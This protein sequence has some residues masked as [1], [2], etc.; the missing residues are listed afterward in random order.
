MNEQ[1]FHL[2]AAETRFAVR[3]WGAGDALLCVHGGMG[4]DASYLAVEGITGLATAQRRVILYDQRGHGGSSPHSEG[5]FSI[6]RW[7]R[8]VL[9]VADALNLDRFALLG[10][11]YG[12]FIAISAAARYPDRI[13]ALVL[14]GTSAGPVPVS[15]PIVPD[16]QALKAF[17]R[18]RWPYFFLGVG[19]HWDLFDELS[20]SVAPFNDAFQCELPVYDARLLTPRLQ[21]STL[22]LAGER[23]GYLPAM[24]WLANRLPRA[25]LVVLSQAGHM[26]FIER[27]ADFQKATAAFLDVASPGL[28]GPTE[29]LFS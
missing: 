7:S 5:P 29:P 9:A 26:P 20:F 2:D 6:D 11:S 1:A 24:R 12:G 8:D 17:Y 22:L 3:Q 28:R 13:A 16:E 19:K 14:V 27:P 10:H 21:M 4:I 18:E 23:D 25:R 15:M